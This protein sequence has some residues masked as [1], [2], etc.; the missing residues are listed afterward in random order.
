MAT[1]KANVL[2]IG[3]GGREHA[4]AWKLKQ[5]ERVGS[6]FTAPENATEFS[7]GDA[8]KSLSSISLVV[9][10]PEQQICDGWTEALSP[11][12]KVFAPSKAASI[13]ESSKTFSKNF[14]QRVGIPTA[15]F[16]VF[17][18]PAEAISYLE[19]SGK[20]KFVIKEDGLRAGKGVFI[21]DDIEQAIERITVLE[22]SESSPVVIE[23]FLEGYEVSAL[24]FTDGTSIKRMPFSQ[25]HKRALEGDLGENTGGMGAIAPLFLPLDVEAEIDNILKQTVSGLATEKLAYRGVLYAGLMITPDG[26]KV[27]EYNCRFGDPETQVLMR[28][29]K[30]DLYDICV[31][32]VD[33]TLNETEISWSHESA[34]GIVIASKGY[35]GNFTKGKPITNIPPNTPEVVTFF[36]G[37][38]QNPETGELV[39]SGGRVLCI[40]ATA[41]SINEG[42]FKALE[43][44]KHVVFSEKFYRRDI[45][46]FVTDHRQSL[47]YA[48]AGVDITEGNNL[49]NLI[50]GACKRTLIPGTED[51]GGFGALVDLKKA[52]FSDPQLVLGMDGVGTKIE[53]A[54]KA[55]K[56]DKLGYDLVGMC[57]NDVLC[58]GAAP[59]AFLDYYVTGKLKATA[60]SSVVI[61]VA[62]AC[63][64]AG[65]ALVG[66]ETAEMPGVYGPEQWDLA[67]CCIGAKERHWANIPDVASIAPGDVLIGIASNG[68]HSNGFSLVRAVLSSSGTELTDKLPWNETST[69]ADELLKPTKLYVKSLLPLLKDSKLKAISHITGGGL[70]ENVPRV[71]PDGLT[72][73][74]D[75]ASIETPEIFKWIQKTGN[76][77]PSE[78]YRTFNCGIGIVAVVSEDLEAYVLHHLEQ[79]HLAAGVIGKLTKKQNIGSTTV[80]LLNP[81]ANFTLAEVAKPVPMANV[82]ILISGSGSNMVNLIEASFKP[83]SH[84][85]VRLVISNKATAG[86]LKLARAQ[87]IETLVIPHGTD[88]HVFEE[89]VD[90]ALRER[91]IDFIC[92]AGF[93]RILTGSFT[94]KWANRIIN[95][96]PSILPSFKG[97]HAVPL[98]L[99]AGVK[100]TGCTAHFVCEEVDAGE[101][102][103]QEVVPVLPDD[104]ESS[105]HARIQQKE[106]H[107]FP[108]VMEL[109]ASRIVKNEL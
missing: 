65:C 46:H 101:I 58:Y 85:N 55:G 36:A 69:F 10:G 48:K 13:I 42:K 40:T 96:H 18:S 26:P 57:V 98:A 7:V 83:Q 95:I 41:K 87:G 75:C 74:I 51:I 11:Y 47:S 24:C 23:E 100:V 86:G 30:S 70:I 77:A 38:K 93:M 44:A 56:F 64:E 8:L 105:L 31:A 53:I 29:L 60:A 49:I 15:E 5:S 97:A 73:E 33:G 17:E 12:A 72:A 61:G 79:N 34:I 9:I 90:A 89:K 103:A 25:D 81:E 62:E 68:L 3:S 20:S 108:I 106:H 2:V 45:G 52:G 32:C 107:I 35:P 67:G 16:R 21:V 92:L 71:L 99:K 14:M 84:A 82:A 78:M 27:L 80:N 28:L 59:L 88:R 66:G 4:L 43:T 91:S 6:V 94:N 50:K 102:L 37:V 19:K 54:S 109:V 104:T 63:A 76:I 22:I 39:N 1:K